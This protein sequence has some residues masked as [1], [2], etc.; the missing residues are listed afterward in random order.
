MGK[1]TLLTP[2]CSAGNNERSVFIMKIKKMLLVVLALC[3]AFAISCEG[4]PPPPR[5]ADPPPAQPPVQPTTPPPVTPAQPSQDL[6]LDGAQAYSVVRGDTLS[7]IAGRYYGN[8][9][10]YPV[11]ALGSGSLI[12]DIDVIDPE[13]RLTIPN[14]QRNLDNSGTRARIKSYLREVAAINDNR[15]RTKDG[16][17]LRKLSDSL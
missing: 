8:G 3:F 1:S 11:I 10:Y 7:S 12:Q 6:I 4:N 14:L 2:K 13:M 16:E 9:Y 17:E 5:P 15:G